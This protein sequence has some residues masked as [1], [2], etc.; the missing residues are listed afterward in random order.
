M[1]EV[2]GFTGAML[3]AAG[4]IALRLWGNEVANMPQMYRPAIYS[5]L[6][7]YYYDPQSVYN[8]AVLENGSLQALLLAS[9]DPPEPLEAWRFLQDSL[10]AAGVDYALSYRRYLDGNRHL[11]DTF[12]LENEAVLLF[13]ASI[14]PGCGRLLMENFTRLARQN[15]LDSMLLWTDNTC[16]YQYYFDHGF[17]LLHRQTAEP[18]LLDMDLETLIFR[19][20]FC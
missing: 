2:T 8:L 6:V 9:V 13:F 10:P 12:K 1:V 17:Q 4:E 19:R 20:K 3:P 7:H 11:E 15:D 18:G 14:Q 5:Y 16:N